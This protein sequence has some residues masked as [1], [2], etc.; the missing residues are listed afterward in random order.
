MLRGL[1]Y[2]TAATEAELGLLRRFGRRLVSGSRQ[3]LGTAKWA[4]PTVAYGGQAFHNAEVAATK[5]YEQI[6]PFLQ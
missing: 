4:I 1:L 5:V 2:E 3:L 6:E